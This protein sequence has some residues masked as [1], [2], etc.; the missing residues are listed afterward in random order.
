M[1]CFSYNLG[2]K[3]SV[4]VFSEKAVFVIDYGNTLFSGTT[5]CSKKKIRAAYPLV[6][7]NVLHL[8]P[9]ITF[10]EFF[11]KIKAKM[12]QIVIK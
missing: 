2:F 6:L 1:C 10:F 5:A 4:K 3:I 9:D 12:S 8:N 7:E 11:L